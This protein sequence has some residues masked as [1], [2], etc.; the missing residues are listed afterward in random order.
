ML[1][2]YN[3]SLDYQFLSDI[4]QNPAAWGYSFPDTNND[5][6]WIKEDEGDIDSLHKADSIMLECNKRVKPYYN[7][8]KSK[9]MDI[10]KSYD[11]DYA[12]KSASELF[13]NHVRNYYFTTLLHKI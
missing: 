10:Y 8:N 9:W 7:K 5:F 6:F 1:R 2:A 4:E 3:E 13:V 12:N 11:L